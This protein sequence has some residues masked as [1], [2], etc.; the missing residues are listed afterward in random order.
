MPHTICSTDG[1]D[2][3]GAEVQQLENRHEEMKE[4]FFFFVFL[5]VCIWQYSTEPRSARRKL[6]GE[7]RL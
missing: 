4:V 7:T 6:K 5:S 2:S 1:E 3:Q